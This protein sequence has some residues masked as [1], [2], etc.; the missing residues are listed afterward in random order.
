MRSNIV[1]RHSR[2][3][4]MS[5]N[6]TGTNRGNTRPLSGVCRLASYRSLL[7]GL[8]RRVGDSIWFLRATAWAAFLSHRGRQPGRLCCVAAGWRYDLRD[9]APFCEASMPKPRIGSHTGTASNFR[10]AGHR[11]RHDEAG[12]LALY[13]RRHSALRDIGLRAV[14]GILQHAVARGGFYGVAVMTVPP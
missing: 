3:A 9:E 4:D 10:S 14:C 11:L 2:H 12:Y 13:A 7:S 6:H 1:E 5:S 8:L